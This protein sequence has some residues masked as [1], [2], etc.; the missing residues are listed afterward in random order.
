MSDG[1]LGLC[2]QKLLSVQTML[3]FPGISFQ[4]YADAL[5]NANIVEKALDEISSIKDAKEL[6]FELI[7]RI[8]LFHSYLSNRIRPHKD[9]AFIK[10]QQNILEKLFA[11]LP[12]YQPDSLGEKQILRPKK[13][14]V[15]SPFRIDLGM[16]GLSDLPPWT[17]ERPGRTVSMCAGV[18]NLPPIKCIAEIVEKQ[19]VF[20]E[21]VGRG[22][23]ESF[24]TWKE[25]NNT[26]LPTTIAQCCLIHLLQPDRNNEELSVFIRKLFD[27]GLKIK[28]I[29]KVPKGLGS[30]SIIA[31]VVLQAIMRLLGRSIDEHDIVHRT[32]SIE[33][34]INVSGGWEDCLA[35]FN[36]GVV[37]ADSK[38]A[39]H[40]E[41]TAK[42]I[43][44]P[45]DFLADMKNR[46]LLYDT[47]IKGDSGAVLTEGTIGYLTGNP[48][49]IESCLELIEI[50]GNVS[51]AVS[52]GDFQ[53]LGK[54]LTRQWEAWKI[55]TNKRCTNQSIDDLLAGAKPWI[56]GAKVNG[57]GSGGAILFVVKVGQKEKL[58]EY[59]TGQTGS[60]VNWTLSKKGY[61]IDE[62]FSPTTTAA[63]LQKSIPKY[64]QQNSNIQLYGR[65]KSCECELLGRAPENMTISGPINPVIFEVLNE[66]ILSVTVTASA[67]V[68]YI[69]TATMRNLATTKRLLDGIASKI[70]SDEIKNWRYKIPIH[71]SEGKDEKGE[72]QPTINGCNESGSYQ[73]DGPSMVLDL[74]DGTT[75]AAKGLP[76]AYCLAAIGDGLTPF[77]DLQAYAIL[78]PSRILSSLDINSVPEKSLKKNIAIIAESIGKRIEDL[79]VVCHSEDTGNH[80]QTMIRE[81]KSMGVKVI[82]PNP[83]IVEAPYTLAACLESKPSVDIV[84]GVFGLPEIILNTILC[85]TLHR[86]KGIIFSIVG[87]SMLKDKDACN[88]SKLFTITS[89]ELRMIEKYGLSFDRHFTVDDIISGNGA[90]FAA[91]VITE[92][93]LL[94]LKGVCQKNSSVFVTSWLVDPCGNV[95]KL[96]VEFDRPN[97]IDYPSRYTFPLHDIS[98]VLQIDETIGGKELI[99]RI[100]ELTNKIRSTT[101]GLYFQPFYQSQNEPGLHVT[102]FEFVVDFF[103][104]AQQK[105]IDFLTAFQASQLSINDIV[106]K[107]LVTIGKLKR[108]SN[109][110]RLTVFIEE[111]LIIAMNKI[112]NYL[113]E[114]QRFHSSKGRD[115]HITIAQFTQVLSEKSLFYLDELIEEYNQLSNSRL[116]MDTLSLIECNKTPFRNIVQKQAVTLRQK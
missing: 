63:E 50:A 94:G 90:A 79:T 105:M 23:E 33:R 80:H 46:M 91:S 93:K 76:G 75:L 104:V 82:V 60:I 10:E 88:L 2:K 66:L 52:K 113:S 65:I 40:P 101:N 71:V 38:P 39:A 25:L 103:P 9:D 87:N 42:Q 47:H 77:P 55:V 72:V 98:L 78:G 36:G 96:S 51:E 32:I 22:A 67:L 74:I 6:G 61:Q 111:S 69:G 5:V 114:T 41:V 45:E 62:W 116:L 64:F 54:L 18:D 102:L 110:I 53:Q 24:F 115:F 3:Q 11:M 4:N 68:N 70:Y 57:A 99:E 112:E 26:S 85:S 97:S 95:F 81:L 19:G 29:S 56:D 48:E 108:F 58:M 1:I 49:V 27:G 100:E 30:S 92:D 106:G 20:L 107:Q 12:Y 35:A 84:I 59:L 21:A 31:S 86:D 44:F 37:I 83:V 73:K 16:G 15:S 109:T 34:M 14:E 28:T 13:V 43:S 8:M 7:G 17:V 89:E